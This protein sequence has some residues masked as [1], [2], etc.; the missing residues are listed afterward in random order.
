M[1][2]SENYS[3]PDAIVIENDD[4]SNYNP[5]NILPKSTEDLRKI[6]EWLEPA[7]YAI[8]GGELPRHLASYADWTGQW[9][10]ST[11]GHQQWFQGLKH[12][13]LCIKGVPGSG[14]SVH[15]AKLNEGL[16]HTHRG[17]QVLFFF[18]QQIIV[19]HH[20]PLAPGERDAE[21]I[22][23]ILLTVG[24]EVNARDQTGHSVFLH[25]ISQ[26]W[27]KHDGDRLRR[28]IQLLPDRGTLPCVR[29][30]KGRT[31]LHK[32]ILER[33]IWTDNAEEDPHSDFLI[34][35]GLDYSAVDRDGN[36]LL[37][38]LAARRDSIRLCGYVDQQNHLGRTPLHILCDVRPEDVER[39]PRD[40]EPIDFVLART[41]NVNIPD[42]DGL[43][44]LRV[45]SM[46]TE[47]CTRKLLDS[48]A[49]PR[50]TTSENSTPLRLAA[51]SRK[52]NI[53]GMLLSSMSKSGKIPLAN[54]ETLELNEA[55]DSHQ[56]VGINAV[57][58]NGFSAL[59]DAA[60][61][62][63]PKT[64]AILLTTGADVHAGADLFK[65]CGEFEEENALY[66]NKCHIKR[67]PLSQRE[68][69]RRKA[70]DANSDQDGG[71]SPGKEFG[72][73]LST[74]ETSR[75]E[76]I[77]TMLVEFGAGASALKLKEQPFE[78]G[79]IST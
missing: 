69:T 2:D 66:K 10:T 65:A 68:I 19:A 78:P 36:S 42:Y 71:P 63:R 55:G 56:V 77:V 28:C 35:I 52:S 40:T 9:L 39:N 58:A 25:C 50:A 26:Q 12:G 22:L 32:I 27:M 51:R 20:S 74:H 15:A 8:F 44:A 13:L 53:V 41:K 34:G 24:A 75:L 18:F 70:E 48:G 17:C 14:K 4:V 47:Y 76:E 59:Y 33:P 67:D 7:S 46:R 6:R 43:T 45:A 73:S 37:H 11:D 30:Y 38:A 64:V 62:G 57:D 79:I 54:L 72:I 21:K 60:R 61:S 16:G 5:G 3:E 49:D 29:D 23:D 31:C 1:S